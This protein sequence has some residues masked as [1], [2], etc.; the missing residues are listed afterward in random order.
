MSHQAPQGLVLLIC[1]MCLR[2]G[3]SVF[4]FSPSFSPTSLTSNPHGLWKEPKTQLIFE[5]VC[6]KLGTGCLPVLSESQCVF[7]LA[8]PDQ[9]WGRRNQDLHKN[10]THKIR[11]TNGYSYNRQPQAR[12]VNVLSMR[13]HAVSFVFRRC[14]SA[15]CTWPCRLRVKRPRPW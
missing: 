3:V 8:L 6:W 12:V 13:N 15:C 4:V 2:L 11:N 7:S 5:I 9:F 14:F 10:P 1:Y